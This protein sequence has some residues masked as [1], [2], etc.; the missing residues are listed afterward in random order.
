MLIQVKTNKME[1]RMKRKQITFK[2]LTRI[3]DLNNERYNRN[4]Y[5]K[6]LSEEY[7]FDN[8]WKMI[9]EPIMEHNHFMGEPI[10]SHVRCFVYTTEN[11]PLRYSKTGYVPKIRLIQDMSWNQYNS[12]VD[13]EL[14]TS[15]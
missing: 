8:D 9:V 1:D 15:L 3:S 10:E 7:G 2:E 5:V 4:V 14:N 13:V 12:L 6:K 11:K